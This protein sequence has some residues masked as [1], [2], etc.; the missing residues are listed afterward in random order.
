MIDVLERVVIPV[1]DDLGE[2]L[3]RLRE[4]RLYVVTAITHG[5]R[6]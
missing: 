1:S 4:D 3:L 6:K 5:R 2:G